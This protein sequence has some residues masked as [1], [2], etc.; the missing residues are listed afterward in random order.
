MRENFTI[1]YSST[2][3]KTFLLFTFTFLILYFVANQSFVFLVFFINL[4]YVY[5]KYVHAPLIVFENETI[6]YNSFFQKNLVLGKEMDIEVNDKLIIF[7][8]RQEQFSIK[9]MVLEHKD[10][11]RLY[12]FINKFIK[13][14]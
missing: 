6:Y 14:K 2:Y 4:I 12:D 5:F 10:K 11:E 9:L 3:K 13:R 1:H 7:R 8:T